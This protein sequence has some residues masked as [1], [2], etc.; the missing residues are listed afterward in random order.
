MEAAQNGLHDIGEIVFTPNVSQRL[1][2]CL[3]R[4]P[5]S[6]TLPGGGENGDYS[7]HRFSQV[8]QLP[9]VQHHYHWL[10]DH[11]HQ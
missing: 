4:P 2:N 6:K 9:V 7:E 1:L 11:D 5:T 3:D 8:Q 10:E